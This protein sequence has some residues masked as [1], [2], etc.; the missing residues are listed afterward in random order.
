MIFIDLAVL[1]CATPSLEAPWFIL[2]VLE[3]FAGEEA[4]T[5]ACRA[6]GSERSLEDA[7]CG[8]MRFLNH[9]WL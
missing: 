4:F 1:L 3:L 2:H 6:M 5:E 7:A 8:L 9:C